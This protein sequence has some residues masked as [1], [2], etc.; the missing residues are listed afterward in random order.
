MPFEP[1]AIV[2]RACI[3]P[4][5][6]SP[7]ALWEAVVAGR[8]LLTDVPKGRWGIAPSRILATDPEHSEDRTWSQRGGY[9][10]GFDAIFDPEG[11]LVPAKQIQTLDPLFQWVFHTAREALAPIAD[12]LDRS[13]TGVIFGNLSFPSSTFSRYAEGVW[14]GELTERLGLPEIDARNRFMSGLPAHLLARGL[15]LGAGAFALDA[16]CA[17]SLYAIKLACDQLH[18]R[19]A[20][21]MLAGA[22]NRA[23][24]LFIHVG[25]SALSALSRRGDSRPF[26]R[27]ADGLIPGEGAGFVALK[28]LDDALEA[29]DTIHGVIRGIGLS[30]DGRDGG[31][32]APSLVG[33]V[34]AMREAYEKSGLTPAD[35]SYVECHATGT[36]VGDTIEIESMSEVFGRRAPLAIGSLK[37]NIGHLITVAGVAGLIKT[38]EAMNAGLRPPT[39]KVGA[40]NPALA[41]SSFYLP[42]G[43]E[44]WDC[45]G[46]RRAAISA[47]GFGGSNAHLIVEQ[48]QAESEARRSGFSS[49]SPDSALCEIAV[50]A[51]GA[52]VGD[53][54]S[55]ADFADDLFLSRSRVR[56][57]EDGIQGASASDITLSLKGSKSPPN[58]LKQTIAQ[59][60]MLLAAAREALDGLDL[61][62][63]RTAVLIGSQC[64]PEVAR[65]GA[66]WRTREW[67]AALDLDE[68][69]IV[70]TQAAIIPVLRAAGVVGNMPNIPANRLNQHFNFGGPSYTLAAEELSGIRALEV[71]I[72]SL[73]AGDIDAAI[74]GAVDLSCEPVHRA[75]AVRLLSSK[76]QIGG[77]AAIIFVLRRLDDARASGEPILAVLTDAPEIDLPQLE[78]SAEREVLAGLFG[79]AHAASG[80][81]H[82][83][84]GVVCC[85]RGRFPEQF[86]MATDEFRG[87]EVVCV[88]MEGESARIW[89][90]GESPSVRAFSNATSP[91]EPVL[92]LPAHPELLNFP[93]TQRKAKIDEEER[94]EEAP[95]LPNTIDQFNVRELSILSEGFPETYV[96]PP[97]PGLL[98]T[99]MGLSDA[100]P[101]VAREES[102]L[103]AIT[104]PTAPAVSN[105][106]NAFGASG[107]ESA[108]TVPAFAGPAGQIMAYRAHVT[109]LHNEFVAQQTAIHNQFLQMRQNAL[110]A[111]MGSPLSSRGQVASE[112]VPV[113]ANVGGAAPVAFKALVELPV[114][115]PM[116]NDENAPAPVPPSAAPASTSLST[117]I[118]AT[119]DE[120]P[121]PTGRSWTRAELE[122]DAGGKISEIFGPLFEQQDEYT[123]QVRMPMPPLLLATRVTGIDALPGSMKRGTVWTETDVESDAWYLHQGRMPAGVM[124]ESGQA[125]LFLI[126]YLGVDFLNKG[127]RCYRL[128]GCEMT[129]YR[130][131]PKPGETLCYDI[132]VDGHANQGDI[133]LFFFHYD[134]RIG[135]ELAAT[136]RN[137]QAGF[138]TREELDDSAGILWTPEEQEIRADARLDAPAV[139]VHFLS[140]S[141]DQ[142][143][144]FADGD[145]AGC[146]GAGFQRAKTHTRTPRI[147]SGE[148]LFL[149]EV[150][151]FDV[152]GGPWGRG[153]LRATK[154]V[155]PDDWFFKGHFKND[156]CMPGTLMFEGCIQMMTI[157]LTGLGYTLD[158]DAWRFEPIPD[159]PYRMVCRGQVVPTSRELVYEIFVEEVHDGPIPMIYAD[160]LCSVDGLGAFHARR[161]GLRL[162]PDWPTEKIDALLSGYVES[163]A[164]ASYQ[165]FDFDYAS[166]LACAWGK[167]S[168]AFGPMYERFDGLRRVARLPGPPYHFL[169]R[170]TDLQTTPGEFVAGGMVEIEY[171]IPD[172]SE[173]YFQENGCETMPYAVHLEAVLQPCGWL[174]SCVGSALTNDE[175]LMFRNLDG[176]ATVKAEVFPSSG[177]IRSEV[178]ITSISRMGPMIIQSFEVHSFVGDVE[179]WELKTVFGFFPKEALEKQVGL[180]IDEAQREMLEGESSYEVDLASR[181][182]QYCGGELRLPGPM[183]LMIDRV[184]AYDP[185]GGRY[186]KGFLRAEKDIDSDEWCF[187]AHFFQDPVQPGSLGIEAM[188]NLLQF[189]MI[190]A[191]LGRDVVAPRFEPIIIGVEHSWKYR[192]QVIPTNE[193]VSVTLEIREVGEDERGV[194]ALADASLWVDGR[195]IYEAKI[196]ARIVG[197]GLNPKGPNGRTNDRET[198]THEELLDPE[199][200]TW[201]KD[202]LPTFTA[203]V[204]PLMSMVDRL[205]GAVEVS[206]GRKVVALDGVQVERW[207]PIE[208]PT[209][210]RTSITASPAGVGR[211]DVELSAWRDARDPRLSRFEVVARG[212]VSTDEAKAETK[213][214]VTSDV[215]EI[216]QP[217]ENAEIIDDVY[218][219]GGLFHGPAFHYV[220]SLRLGSNGSDFS[221]DVGAG[222]VP[223]GTLHQGLLDALTHCIPHDRLNLCSSKISPD[224]VAYPY[225][226]SEMRL[227]GNPPSEGEVRCE[228]RFDG[229]DGDDRFP[230][231]RVKAY[232]GARC[233]VS[234]RLVEVLLPKGPL[235]R[236]GALDRLRFFRER[237]FVEGMT[238]SRVAE[239]EARLSAAEV[240]ASD[241]LPGTMASSYDAEGDDVVREMVIKDFVAQ[242]ERVHPSLVRIVEGGAVVTNRPL[243]RIPL[244]V[245][246]DGDDIV[247]RAAGEAD[248]DTGEV[249][250]FWR[251]WFGIGAFPVEDVY[252]G[253]MS[254]FVEAVHVTDAHAMRALRGKPVLYL[255]NHQVGIESLLFSIIVSALNRTPTLTLAKVEHRETWLGRLIAHCLAYPGVNDPGMIAYFD[256]ENPA[257]LLKIVKELAE[258]ISGQPRSL[259]IHV[260]GTRALSCAQPIEK[261]SGVFIDM[262]LELNI[263][264][265]PVRFTGGL[266]RKAL[267]ERTE[268]PV[269]LGK[270]EYW[271]GAPL[272]PEELSALPYKERTEFVLAAI[273][274]LGV[275]HR[276]ERPAEANTA[277]VADVTY[278]KKRSGASAPDT[279]LLCALRL[280]S[281][282]GEA[283]T[284]LI[285]GSRSGV[286]KIGTS[287]EEAWLGELAARLYGDGDDEQESRVEN[288]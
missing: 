172:A 104:A 89:L 123:V 162:V 277:L 229:F 194:F 131:L 262:A 243:D 137:G 205:A 16:A 77:D 214:G 91:E 13:R 269:E 252:Y 184:T 207:L 249:K 143:R 7:E 247:V 187:K 139:E 78:C 225:R 208:G 30:N 22:V 75:A 145:V 227:D 38:L 171:D 241:W 85:G 2:G 226:I 27:A 134:C 97:A 138:F 271:L 278:W 1:I 102:A 198:A 267:A 109:L 232:V 72:R 242:R 32:L 82:V 273:N 166:L 240:R 254:S 57:G 106:P 196:G 154:T 200:D 173:W 287:P 24:D 83:A 234:L 121:R 238:L 203:P 274:G 34:R 100:V 183:L 68:D 255:G 73:K 169:S 80:L 21:T 193:R 276:V 56:V 6:L 212:E 90:R 164:V 259:M 285:E 107:A 65:Y 253:L 4:G 40:E 119:R 133:R 199:R 264:I 148:M 195:R 244:I 23:D 132:H 61:P 19:K 103:V 71:G 130:S 268:F 92:R 128:L 190:E 153:Y 167:P 204:L 15:G 155:S 58:D 10:E 141:A 52:R 189:Y 260:E 14:F 251:E 223:R 113:D 101:A 111:L 11:F 76:R 206:T 224:D 220:T 257:S 36:P 248:F 66:R 129:F 117:P 9:V 174:A 286:L 3:L 165:G 5:A 140:L 170:I 221:L 175:D 115:V 231:F 37:A 43:P 127:E 151:D 250:A 125:D 84:A 235:G 25:F 261:M 275:G 266:P 158:K 160:L 157:Y 168:A 35:I 282:P 41:S 283:M 12:G 178:K 256:R 135:G 63:N 79:H 8:D 28:R 87:L 237:A 146:F 230:A 18:D 258:G 93:A 279:T 31:F 44:S 163:K 147:Q 54:Q 192:G 105:T 70:E 96:M 39:P 236:V 81:L 216:S 42:D 215:G 265:V 17:S 159:E 95:K 116:G 150:T 210:L 191:E 211:F 33:Q 55:I 122:I 246:Q 59:Q 99:V 47:F 213:A 124:I 51:M 280:M 29:G 74:V 202:H 108:A 201:L 209:K 179:V 219:E 60:T 233:W 284:R 218:R 20:N 217:L 156:P 270:Q 94:M 118:S 110:F 161:V 112:G 176:T 142:I 45:A 281:Q 288:R 182:Q 69:W 222:S 114:A 144:A 149:D 185:S 188:I 186:E 228:M 180:P 239:G 64:D 50:V 120:V 49:A 48:W 62:G 272:M 126:S 197:G 245:S 181:P 177:T 67:A 98:E 46:P 53:G 263:P 86:E 152:A 136:M 88:A 26:D